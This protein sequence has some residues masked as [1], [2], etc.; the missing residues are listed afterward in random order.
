MGVRQISILKQMLH[1]SKK[2]IL[3]V[4]NASTP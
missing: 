4:N 1:V 2:D 3:A